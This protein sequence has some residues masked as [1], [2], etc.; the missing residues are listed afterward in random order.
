MYL[1]AVIVCLTLVG[2]PA[3]TVNNLYNTTYYEFCRF[4][5]NIA[6]A[7]TYVYVYD[8]TSCECR[9][10]YSYRL[11]SCDGFTVFNMATSQSFL[12][13]NQLMQLIGNNLLEPD[14][15][16]NRVRLVH[17]NYHTDH[18]PREGDI[19][20]LPEN[21]RSCK[22]INATSVVKQVNR[23]SDTYQCLGNLTYSGKSYNDTMHGELL[24][25]LRLKK[26]L[27]L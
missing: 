23:Y 1:F 2:V 21:I 26:L 14:Y 13:A 18:P 10:I 6:D 27:G 11:C 19:P 17:V 9:F 16:R 20:E 25:H 4:A 15:A 12:C 8:M 7:Q 24:Q 5:T 22:V 3:K